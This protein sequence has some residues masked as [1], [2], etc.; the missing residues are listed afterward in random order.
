M[1]VCKIHNLMALINLDSSFNHSDVYSINKFHAFYLNNSNGLNLIIMLV[2]MYIL[3]HN[4]IAV[5]KMTYII[6]NEI[7]IKKKLYKSNQ[8]IIYITDIHKMNVSIYESFMFPFNMYTHLLKFYLCV[9]AHTDFIFDIEDSNSIII[10]IKCASD[11]QMN[12]LL[13][14]ETYGGDIAESKNILSAIRT[15]QVLN[16]KKKLNITCV[17]QRYSYS[18]GTMLA[19]SSDNLI[20]DQYASLSPTDPQINIDFEGIRY[21]LSC[22]LY[23]GV[24]SKIKHNKYINKMNVEKYLIIKDRLKTHLDNIRVFKKLRQFEKISPVHR[25]GVIDI[26]CKNIFMDHNSPIGY[27]DLISLGLDVIR[28]DS[29]HQEIFKLADKIKNTIK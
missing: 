27:C 7:S 11:N 4:F 29:N 23:N 1:V 19:L 6:M 13:L 15:Y 25:N 10:A 20:M 5:C 14:L 3:L 8:Y 2:I 18:A 16:E 12:I 28:I 24:I 9:I 21:D 17:I 26:F 22:E